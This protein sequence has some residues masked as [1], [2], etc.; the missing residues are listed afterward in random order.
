[1]AL[2]SLGGWI[3]V[4]LYT[5][6]W[7]STAS[8]M[9]T[10]PTKAFSCFIYLN[11]TI[12]ISVWR[13]WQMAITTSMTLRTD[14]RSKMQSRRQLRLQRQDNKQSPKL[15]PWCW[16]N[17][18]I[19]VGIRKRWRWFRPLSSPNFNSCAW[20]PPLNEH[21]NENI[22]NGHQKAEKWMDD[23]QV[24]LTREWSWLCIVELSCA[25]NDW[26]FFFSI[27]WVEIRWWLHPFSIRWISQNITGGHLN[28]IAR[29]YP[30]HLK[31]W[32]IYYFFF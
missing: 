23:Q 15:P 28:T 25:G 27:S 7:I 6:S 17:D 3:I 13:S 8:T 11:D 21:K 22:L 19:F 30:L 32:K 31:D 20:N 18:T 2:Y 10:S 24:Y 26:N 5:Q 9:S 1:M 16:T 29:C 4:S 12:H 14:Q